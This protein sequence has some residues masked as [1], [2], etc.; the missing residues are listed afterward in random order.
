MSLHNIMRPPKRV[1]MKWHGPPSV[2]IT[3]TMRQ[4]YFIASLKILVNLLSYFTAK[5]DV[6]K[7]AMNMFQS[8][9]QLSTPYWATRILP[10]RR[11]FLMRNRFTYRPSDIKG[12]STVQPIFGH[13]GNTCAL[14]NMSYFFQLDMKI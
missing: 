12:L 8:C 13:L 5:E 6:N 10:Q 2:T 7:K 4:I 1:H 11:S 9:P 3:F 14:I